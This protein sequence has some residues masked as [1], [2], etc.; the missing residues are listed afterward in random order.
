MASNAEKKFPCDDVMWCVRGLDDCIDAMVLCQ[1]CSNGDR[2]YRQ[3]KRIDPSAWF[4]NKEFMFPLPRQFYNADL[5]YWRTEAAKY[6][7]W[8]QTASFVVVID[9]M[10]YRCL[11]PYDFNFYLYNFYEFASFPLT[12]RR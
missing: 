4:C 12:H 2:N 10:V 6:L 11:H 5:Q 9:A 7:M 1:K 3:S 8:I